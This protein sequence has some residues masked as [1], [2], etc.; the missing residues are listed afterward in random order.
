MDRIDQ[1]PARWRIDRSGMT[2]GK[3]KVR[4]LLKEFAK[5][6]KGTDPDMSSWCCS[7]KRYLSKLPPPTHTQHTIDCHCDC[8]S[9][10]TRQLN[11]TAEDIPC[12]IGSRQV[13][14]AGNKMKVVS[15]LDHPRSVS[16]GRII[17]HVRIRSVSW[18]RIDINIHTYVWNLCPIL[19]TDEAKCVHWYN[20]HGTI[21]NW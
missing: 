16:W 20:R 6:D 5:Q 19:P 9:T 10:R 11:P 13:N 2:I 1:S 7:L 12:S 3:S 17:S 8:V 18:E 14:Q 4:M 21:T 15:L